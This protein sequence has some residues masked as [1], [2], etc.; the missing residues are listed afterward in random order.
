[1]PP[2]SS[3]ARSKKC[4]EYA[5]LSTLTLVLAVPSCVL[6]VVCGPVLAPCVYR[7]LFEVKLLRK[8][9]AVRVW[10]DVEAEWDPLDSRLLLDIGEY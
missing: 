2:K 10:E 7:M 9:C 3:F 4:L 6:K 8:V 1:V 5:S